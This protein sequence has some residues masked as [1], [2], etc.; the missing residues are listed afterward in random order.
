MSSTL[1]FL[2]FDTADATI[3]RSPFNCNFQLATPIKHLYKVFFKSVELPVG[4]YNIREDQEFQIIVSNSPELL[5]SLQKTNINTIL[6]ERNIET[7][8]TIATGYLYNVL[9]YFIIPAGIYS[10]NALIDL[11]NAQIT[12]YINKCKTYNSTFNIGNITFDIPNFGDYFLNARLTCDNMYNL[13]VGPSNFMTNILGFTAYQLGAYNPGVNHIAVAP[14]LFQLF[15]DTYLNLYFPNVPHNNT[16]F[17]NKFCS[18]KIP[19]TSGLQSINYGGD[20]KDFAQYIII[21]DPNFV[22]NNLAVVMYDRYGREIKS[23]TIYDW[24]FTLGFEI[25]EQPRN[26]LTLVLPEPNKK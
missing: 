20:S 5:S 17:N 13:M 12:A 18:F 19:V 2:H 9:I 8:A 1:S 23:G 4:W 11:I 16:N 22:L 15:S 14:N 6:N 7:I 3:K 25:M 10:Q 26:L 24:S 21:T